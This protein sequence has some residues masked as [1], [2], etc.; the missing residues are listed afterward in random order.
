MKGNYLK[1]SSFHYNNFF[2]VIFCKLFLFCGN[3]IGFA[4]V[5]RKKWRIV[6]NR[7]RGKRISR[8]FIGYDLCFVMKYTSAASVNNLGKCEHVKVC[9]SC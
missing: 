7:V 3:F 9:S 6:A 1:I 5:A 4:S 8:D 2:Q